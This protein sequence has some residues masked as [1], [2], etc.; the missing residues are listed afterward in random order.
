MSWSGGWEIWRDL[1][2]VRKGNGN[3]MRIGDTVRRKER[4]MES[5]L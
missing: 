2:L 3:E 5:S 1:E 4:L